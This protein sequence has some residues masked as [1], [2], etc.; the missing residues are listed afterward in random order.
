LYFL[1]SI[2]LFANIDI[3]RHILV[4]DTSILV[5]INMGR[6]KYFIHICKKLFFQQVYTDVYTTHVQK[7]LPSAF[8]KEKKMLSPCRSPTFPSENGLSV[9]AQAPAVAPH[10]TTTWHETGPTIF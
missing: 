7:L 4:I 9:S 1:R 6:R 10:A 2:I 3:S 5:K 8:L